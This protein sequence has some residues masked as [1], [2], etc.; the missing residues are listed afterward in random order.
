MFGNIYNLDL[1]HWPPARALWLKT[2][3]DY[4]QFG[5]SGSEQAF[6]KF[7]RFE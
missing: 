5:M 1:A 3:Q 7:I 4:P 6:S 2:S